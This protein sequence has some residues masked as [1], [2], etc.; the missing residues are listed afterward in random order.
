MFYEWRLFMVFLGKILSTYGYNDAGIKYI[1]KERD[2]KR[3]KKKKRL[4][5]SYREI[6]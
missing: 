4:K 5:K 3:D 1:E 6:W 2:M